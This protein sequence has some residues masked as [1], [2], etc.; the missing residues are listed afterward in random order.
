MRSSTIFASVVLSLLSFT[1]ANPVWTGGSTAPEPPFPSLT[2]SLPGGPSC[3]KTVTVTAT[4]TAS[5]T[6]SKPSA[7]STTP[8]PTTTSICSI[9]CPIACPSGYTFVCPCTCV[10]PTTSIAPTFTHH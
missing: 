6:T 10:P 2:V 4:V 8:K 9:A 3:T 5:L 1:D 7:T